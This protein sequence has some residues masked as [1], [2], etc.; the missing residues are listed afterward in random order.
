MATVAAK[1]FETHEKSYG[2]YNVKIRIY[3]KNEK[4]YLDTSHFVSKKQLDSKFN[5]K[6]S[7]NYSRTQ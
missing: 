1:V 3:H 6:D 4:K 2:M 5:I 7:Q